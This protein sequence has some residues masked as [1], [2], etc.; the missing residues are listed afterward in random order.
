VESLFDRI[1]GDLAI[2]KLVEAFYDRVLADPELAPFFNATSM[3]T[4]V[5][6]QH[7]YFA[8]AL[9]GP[10]A[11]SGIA[12]RA[13]HSGRGIGER[14]Y[15]RFAGHLLDTLNDALTDPDDVAEISNR[16]TM[17]AD[18]IVGGATVDG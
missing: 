7:E 4:L 14:H 2:A 1:G 10:E 16:L 6:M 3:D 13:A 17:H 5:R 9:G 15:A 8:A 11:Y 12:L 18:D